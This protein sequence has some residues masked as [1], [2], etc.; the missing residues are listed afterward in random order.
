LLVPHQQSQVA[1]LL[2]PQAQAVSKD[3][4]APLPMPL[5]AIDPGHGGI[6]PGTQAVNGLQEKEITLRMAKI[7]G[8][9][10]L[11]RGYRVVLT[12]T[13]DH[14]LRRLD[15]LARVESAKADFFISLH[16]DHNPEKSMC[17]IS[18]YT[19]AAKA[20]DPE[21]AYLAQRENTEDNRFDDIKANSPEIAKILEDLMAREVQARAEKF[22]QL[23]AVSLEKKECLLHKP[24]RSADFLILRSVS[25][26]SVLIELG[27]L[28]S[29]EDCERLKS[30]VFL[31]KVAH[32][33]VETVDRYFTE[34][35]S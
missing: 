26:P 2:N 5:I 1:S 27:C 23:L 30:S 8:K 24:L 20:S 18:V 34:S 35:S 12:R 31:H 32:Y 33:I 3:P 21:S 15:R 28:S 9:A 14:A 10:L 22:A 25:V 7:L 4:P 19:F 29:E 16:A 6:D 11:K 13:R 17:G